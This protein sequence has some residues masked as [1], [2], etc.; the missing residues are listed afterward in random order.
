MSGISR[1]ARIGPYEV[2]DLLGS[3][4]MGEVWRAHD[5]RLGRDVA[6]KVLGEPAPNANEKDWFSREG[7]LLAQLNHPN[8][9]HLYGLEESGVRRALVLEYVP[10]ESLDARVKRGPLPYAEAVDV[11]H[12]AAAALEYAHERGVIHRDLKPANLMR[13]PDGKVKVLDFGLAKSYVP[14]SASGSDPTQARTLVSAVS[15]E[16]LLVGTLSYMS[17][18]QA[19]GKPVG[20][21]TDV[22]G[23]GVLFFELLSGRRP[24]QGETPSDTLASILDRPPEWNLL[25]EGLPRP[26]A[27]FLEACLRKERT[28]RLQTAREAVREIETLV[29]PSAASGSG[30]GSEPTATIRAPSSEFAPVLGRSRRRA[31]GVRLRRGAASLAAGLILVAATW[32][33]VKGRHPQGASLPTTKSLLVLPFHDLTG[34]AAGERLGQ[35]IA[36]TVAVRLSREPGILVLSWEDP[37]NLSAFEANLAGAARQA[38]ATLVLK[39][40]VRREAREVR[41]TWTLVTTP[42]GAVVVGDAVSGGPNEL[43]ALE[44][45]VA[46]RIASSLRL[47]GSPRSSPPPAD[48]ALASSDAQES[49]LQA[50]GALSR[51]DR[52][53]NLDEAVRL[54]AA[55]PSAEGSPLVQAALARAYN[56]KY[57]TTKDPAFATKA[58]SAAAEAARAGG[59]SPAVLSAAGLVQLQAGKAPAAVD[60][61]RRALQKQPD[62]PEALVGYAEALEA[63]GRVPDAARAFADAADRRGS[64]W[65]VLSHAAAFAYRQGRWR[66][67]AAL[68]GRAALLVPDNSRVQVNLA[69]ALFQLDDLQGAHAALDRALASAPTA[70]AWT[71]L[72]TVLYAEGNYPGAASAFEMAC[73]L[74]GVQSLLLVNW[75]DACRQAPELRA[76]APPLYRDAIAAAGKELLVNPDDDE[77][78]LSLAVAHAKL[79]EPA[80]ARAEQQKVLALAGDRPDVLFQCAVVSTLGGRRDEALAH[81]ARAVLAGHSRAAI[82][83]EPELV[84]LKTDP[85]FKA[86]AAPGTPAP[87]APSS[88]SAGSRPNPPAERKEPSR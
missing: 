26:A 57:R 18:E 55:I 35:G 22:W 29:S 59:D 64:S 40:T 79:G 78:R 87:S 19:R 45:R 77:A 61:F 27:A 36:Q 15:G 49:Y 11:L 14:P 62:L 84:Q 44:D 82:L 31:L 10:G 4:G 17:P 34:D 83:R 25:P 69:G 70:G 71:N 80:A 51:Y 38:G 75:A 32:W 68:F 50:L 73:G 88:P 6:L 9:A 54:L 67:A 60:S 37:T 74:G 76:K 42:G 81:L 24:F 58:S 46:D 41:V 7:R 8:I 3:G 23:L 39:G 12:Q 5:T 16:G 20:P 1:G 66:D 43:L 28:E 86:L 48:P 56:L 65:W 63:S 2:F 85:R 52:P 53:G 30:A 47:P 33:G 13:M 72:G 21:E